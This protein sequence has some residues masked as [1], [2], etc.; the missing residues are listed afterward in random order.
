MRD[1]TMG[2]LRWLLFSGVALAASL[3]VVGEVPVAANGQGSGDSESKMADARLSAA[4]VA[5][6][7]P[8]RRA[9]RPSMDDYLSPLT[10]DVVEHLREVAARAP[11]R[12]DDVFIKVGDSATVNRGFMQCFARS[13]KVSFGEHG[14]L[15]ETA[16][17][18]RGGKAGGRDP[19]RR[20]S[21]A[22][23]VGW[24][25]HDALEGSP[26]P[27]MR[28]VWAASPRFAL[29][30]FGT[31]DIEM[32]RPAVFA[33]RMRAIVDV[34]TARGVIPILSTV[35]PR[36]GDDEADRLVPRYGRVIEAIARARKVPHIR[37]HAAMV[38]LPDRGLMSDGVHPSTLVSGNELRGCDFGQQGLRYGQNVR[39][40]LN[41]RMLDRLRRTVVDGEPAPDAGEAT[42][43]GPARVDAPDRIDRL[44]HTVMR[45]TEGASSNL[46]RYPGC[47]ADSDESGPEHVYRIDLDEPT[48]L[49]LQVLHRRDTD[50][51]VH[52]LGERPTGDAC[53]ARADTSMVA[54]VPAGTHHVVVDTF[55]PEGGQA[56]PGTYVLLVEPAPDAT[57][58][59]D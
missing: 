34:L 27:L 42:P 39:N 37:L 12:R 15:A 29:V 5:A 16:A 43:S 41:L 1:T 54:D 31:N 21:R 26:S 52:L 38:G 57:P 50:M 24:S 32:N 49:R 17:F 2:T 51:D 3:A 59:A 20:A 19:Y 7:D 9:V 36:N 25:A 23:K 55:V 8:P 18:F 30:M 45:S 6:D 22:A 58:G 14:E 48:R 40:L 44:P 13:G 56:A 47:D 11:D 46:A 53:I 4:P 10:P 33:D 28:E 35:I